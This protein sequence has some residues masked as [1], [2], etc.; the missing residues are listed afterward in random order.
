MEV[1]FFPMFTCNESMTFNNG[2]NKLGIIKEF[3]FKKSHIIIDILLKIKL[4][5]LHATMSVYISK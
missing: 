5:N 2:I 4:L 1:G 3:K